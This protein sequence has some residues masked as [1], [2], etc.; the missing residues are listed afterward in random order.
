MVCVG[1]TFFL[2]LL[3]SE[4]KTIVD[5]VPELFKFLITPHIEKVDVVLSPGMTLLRWTSLNLTTYVSE[6]QKS[7]GE[8]EQLIDTVLG[9]HENRIMETFSNM[10]KVP[11]VEVPTH[12]VISIESFIQRTEELCKVAAASLETKSIVV[13]TAVHELMELLLPS[14]HTLPDEI[15]ENLTTPGSLTMKKKIEKRNK[16]QQEADLLYDYYQ[17]LNIDTLL[18]LYKTNLETMRKRVAFA[19]ALTY[20]EF[21]QD[22][23]KD[24]HPLFVADVILSLPNLVM[25]PSLEEIQQGMSYVVQTMLTVV[26]QIYCWGQDRKVTDTSTISITSSTTLKSQVKLEKGSSFTRLKSYYH[27]VAEHKDIL[28][29]VVVLNSSLSST[30]TIVQS[31]IDSF[32]QYQVLWAID[33]DNL[34]AKFSEGSPGVSDYQQEMHSFQQLEEAVQQ[35]PDT[36]VAGAICLHTE[37]LK[38]MLVTEAKQWRVCYGR[39]MSCYYQ[40]IM[41]E[42]FQSIEDWSKLLSRPLKD[43]DDVRSVMA[44]LKDIREN[45]IRID[46]CLGPIE[47]RK[48]PFPQLIPFTFFFLYFLGVLHITS[49]VQYC[50]QSRRSRTC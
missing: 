41:D 1:V 25:K 45:E 20:M 9:I 44:T 47:V 22:E 15:P 36:Q 34:V 6:V 2:K 10:L 14:D 27:T 30:K 40:S 39:A 26:K 28:K 31:T 7:L 17:Q 8:L 50:S 5:K 46:M 12:D 35:E 21:S 49:K 19:S 3:V 16:L 11:L 43:L 38:M 29:L 33:R 18:Q 48:F 24:H 4:Y 42:V 37:Q 32:N 13:E 23:K